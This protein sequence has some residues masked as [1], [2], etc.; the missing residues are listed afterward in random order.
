MPLLTGM[1]IVRCSKNTAFVAVSFRAL[2]QLNE[3]FVLSIAFI[4]KEE[5]KEGMTQ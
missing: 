4:K 2:L 3:K 1:E 5:E